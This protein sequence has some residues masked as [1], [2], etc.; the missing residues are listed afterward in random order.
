M[1]ASEIYGKKVDAFLQTKEDQQVFETELIVLQQEKKTSCLVRKNTIR[2]LKNLYLSLASE[3][4]LINIGLTIGIEQEDKKTSLLR[5]Y[6]FE[7]IDDQT[8]IPDKSMAIELFICLCSKQIDKDYLYDLLNSDILSFY[9]INHLHQLRSFYQENL[10]SFIDCYLDFGQ[11][12]SE[13]K[14]RLLFDFYRLIDLNEID[15]HTAKQVAYFFKEILPLFVD[16]FAHRLDAKQLYRHP[17]KIVTWFIVWRK[18]HT[19]TEDEIHPIDDYYTIEFPTIVKYITEFIW[20]NNGLNIS[21]NLKRFSFGSQG[22]F[23]LAKGGSIRNAPTIHCF[24]RR[25]SKVFVNL[26]YYFN[27]SGLNMFVYCYGK[28]LGAGPLLLEMLQRFMRFH[29]SV[30]DL[31]AEQERWN[32]VIQKLTSDE[33]EVIGNYEAVL[34]MGYLYHCLRDKP[35][36]TVQRKS[37]RELRQESNIY[38]IRIQERLQERQRLQLE[39]QARIKLEKAHIEKWSEHRTV[40]PYKD[41]PYVIVELTTESMLEKEG[42]VMHHCVGSYVKSC[43]KGYSTIWSLRKQVDKKWYSYVTI[44][45]SPKNKIRQMSTRFNGAPKEEHLVHIRKWARKNEIKL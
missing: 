24:T 2:Y 16:R 43:K 26:P 29:Q 10:L 6:F 13:E 36:Y 8:S 31:K 20:W 39:R 42:I 22:F 9:R 21:T 38:N 7:L 41:L 34:L 4:P 37:I 32:P 45:L 12:Y 14:K 11:E 30:D 1:I 5:D 19:K 40:F 23:H 33:F 3:Q 18:H 17:D 28:A 25:M 44:E 15:E 35:D 27:Q